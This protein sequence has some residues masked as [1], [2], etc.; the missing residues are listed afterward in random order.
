MRKILAGIASF[1]MCASALTAPMQTAITNISA[2]AEGNK[3]NY[4]EALQKSMFFYE[5]QQSGKLPEWNNVPWR[6]DSMV[7]EDG[8]ETDIVKGGW[9]DAGDHFKFNLTNAYSASMLAWGYLEYKDA[10][11]KAGLSET[12]LNNLQWGLDFVNGCYLGDGKMVGT[13]GD[14]EGGST[15]HNIWCS[16]EVYL[17]KHHLNNDD[18]E[19]PYDTIENASVAGLGAAALT[20]GYLIFK[21]TQPEKAEAYLKTAKE[22]FEYAD[23]W[24]EVEKS[25]GGMGSMYPTSS[26][27]D[28]CMFAACW[29]YK[30]TGEQAYLDKVE[31][32]YIPNFPT[33]N[34]STEPKYGWGLCWDDTSQAAAYL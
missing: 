20:E 11:E 17:R 16:A 23:T 28:D 13:I 22:L 2:N 5:V 12:Y 31:K 14:F 9:F 24:R 30:A 32:E 25:R 18:W 15:D 7:D 26:W 3:Y 10:V 1:V 6:A 34:Q 33:E 4:A 27:L 29:L 19:R 8:N 21:D